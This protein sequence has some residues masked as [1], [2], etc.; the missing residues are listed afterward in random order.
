MPTFFPAS[1]S[2][3]SPAA[4]DYTPAT[5]TSTTT[6]TT[7]PASPHDPSAARASSK[8]ALPSSA[9][10]PSAADTDPNS[11][12]Y[13]YLLTADLFDHSA[14]STLLNDDQYLEAPSLSLP[15]AQS[16]RSGYTS[17]GSKNSKT[18]DVTGWLSKD[19]SKEGCKDGSKDGGSKDGGSK[20]GSKDGSYVSNA[21]KRICYD[22]NKG[23]CFRNSSCRFRHVKDTRNEDG[24]GGRS[25]SKDSVRSGVST[26]SKEYDYDVAANDADYAGAEGGDGSGAN[27]TG[28]KSATRRGRGR[29]RNNASNYADTSGGGGFASGDGG[30]Y[31]GSYSSNSR[32][33]SKDSKAS[34]VS[35]ASSRGVGGYITNSGSL[36]ALGNS[37]S[38]AAVF[39]GQPGGIV[40]YNGMAYGYYNDGSRDG[41]REGSR[42]GGSRGGSRDGGSSREGS[43]EGSRNS[44]RNG[45]RDSSPNGNGER[46]GHNKSTRV[47]FDYQKGLCFRGGLCKFT[48]HNF[49][50]SGG[51]VNSDSHDGGGNNGSINPADIYGASG[52]VTDSNVVAKVS[53]RQISPTHVHVTHT[54]IHKYEEPPSPSPPPQQ[55]QFYQ[56]NIPPHQ[57]PQRFSPPPQQ[58]QV[59]PHQQYR[60]LSSQLGPPLPEPPPGFKAVGPA[61]PPQLQPVA[62]PQSTP[63]PYLNSSTLY[64]HELQHTANAPFSAPV[65]WLCMK[66]FV[67]VNSETCAQCGGKEEGFDSLIDKILG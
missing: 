25:N 24:V 1:S 61:Q 47:C 15:D 41:S 21:S 42:D 30:Y 20:D 44:S 16:S 6:M 35:V 55:Q 46:R 14:L 29:R 31:S 2:G 40:D 38:S 52:F 33:G 23:I 3:L 64:N 62:P 39:P 5:T 37:A 65:N 11:S 54:I 17:D 18:S 63:Q 10:P 12:Q 8:S 56:S 45:S 60:S 28:K 27:P 13:S 9:V 19:G 50:S 34:A 4:Q 67:S 36:A 51:Y 32:N 43:R 57:Q 26:S 66:C 22:Y 7:A 58:L 49:A 48:H 53:Q 59:S